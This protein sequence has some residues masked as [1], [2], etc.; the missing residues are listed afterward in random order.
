MRYLEAENPYIIARFTTG[1]TVTI[2]I[3]DLADNS[4]DVDGA[5]MAEIGSTGYFKYQFNPDISSLMEYLYIAD[6]GSEEHAGK[7]ILGGFPDSIKDETDKIANIK[8]ETD[9]MNFSGN[10]IQARVADKGVLNNPPSE[11][12]A[13]YKDK[14][15]EEEIKTAIDNYAGKS[16]YKADV[17]SLP[18]VTEIV[19]GIW[20]ERKDDHVLT[21]SIGEHLTLILNRVTA[22]NGL[23]INYKKIKKMIEDERKKIPNSIKEL[24]NV[25]KPVYQAIRDVQKS[26]KNIKVIECPEIPEIKEVDIS[27]V[28]ESINQLHKAIL[29]IRIPEPEKLNLSPILME[30]ERIQLKN[31]KETVK[32]IDENF[33]KTKEALDKINMRTIT[34][35]KNPILFIK[36]AR[37]REENK[38]K[39]I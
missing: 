37:K 25:F 7:I 36:K 33:E 29:N 38:R 18:T 9:K 26:V 4:K 24:E 10:N 12:I 32:N 8:T 21:N 11:S 31:F 14:N 13:D 28:A 17:S 2:D 30:L 20:D 1:D 19:D 34:G 16:T 22:I 27:G 6:N 39:F 15:T 35:K 23:D 3:Y 5:S